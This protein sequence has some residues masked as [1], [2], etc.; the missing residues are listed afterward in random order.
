MHEQ[1]PKPDSSEEKNSAPKEGGLLKKIGLAAGMMAAGTAALGSEGKTAEKELINPD[2]NIE[3]A[4][5]TDTMD[6]KENTASFESGRRGGLE[7]TEGQE[8]F[9]LKVE[10]KPV[11]VS[12][13]DTT[14]QF[15]FIKFSAV[16][17]KDNA[18]VGKILQAMDS[19]HIQP[20]NSEHLKSV[21]LSN[22]KVS[23]QI[24]GY[25]MAIGDKVS[26]G[27]TGRAT[28]NPVGMKMMEDRASTELDI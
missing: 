25:G 22:P 24:G 20:G 3:A 28:I 7:I 10:G 1:P 12:S 11:P 9:G 13:L 17:K 6:H 4:A 21:F 8:L 18:N 23:K 14:K 19:L 26:D 27:N 16:N 5:K 15:F 2:H